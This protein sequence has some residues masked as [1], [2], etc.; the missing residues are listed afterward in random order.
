[1]A[2]GFGSMGAAVAYASTARLKAIRGAI[3][4]SAG[5]VLLLLLGGMLFFKRM[6]RYFADVL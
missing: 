3:M 4:I 6:E 1:M 5:V 2:A